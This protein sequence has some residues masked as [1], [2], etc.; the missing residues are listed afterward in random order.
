MKRIILIVTIAL[1]P[2]LSACFVGK[3]QHCNCPTTTVLDPV[4]SEYGT[5]TNLELSY[6]KGKRLFKKPIQEGFL[7]RY[8]IDDGEMLVFSAIGNRVSDPEASYSGY[9]KEI[10]GAGVTSKDGL[11]V[12]SA[13]S[14]EKN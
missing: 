8:R 1:L 14:F 9:R 4:V 13:F 5:L 11:N 3:L 2:A 10:S 7:V 6:G 12:T